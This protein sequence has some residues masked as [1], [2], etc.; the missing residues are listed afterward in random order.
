[1]VRK[2]LP[3]QL[4][5]VIDAASAAARTAAWL[6]AW[7]WAKLGGMYPAMVDSVIGLFGQVARIGPGQPVMRELVAA[8]RRPGGGGLARVGCGR[9][10]SGAPNGANR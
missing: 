7:Q 6:A 3:D 9:A 2:F 4:W 1:V 5:P 8:V 10:M